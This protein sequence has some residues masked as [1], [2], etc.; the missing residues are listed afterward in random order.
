MKRI[1]VGVIVGLWVL[2]TGTA[3]AQTPNPDELQVGVVIS[4]H[5]QVNT[6][7]VNVPPAATGLDALEA[8]GVD[9][10]AQRGSLGAGICRVQ[11]VGCTPPADTCFCQCQG[12]QCNYWAYHYQE[13]DKWVYSGLGASN[14]KLQNGSVEGWLW[15]EGTGQT[16]SSQ[17]PALT[18]A[19]ICNQTTIAT[20]E[21]INTTANI[22][23]LTVV[24][25]VVFGGLVFGGVIVWVRRRNAA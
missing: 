14:R 11:N 19:G 16:P 13:Q 1:L 4:L 9:V 20:T 18:F 24:G 22:D 8:T 10:L 23:P 12:V 21:P 3:S 7:C 17:L 15:S 6:Y 25:Y 5:G 2:A